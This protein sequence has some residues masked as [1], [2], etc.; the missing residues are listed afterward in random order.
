MTARD[1]DRRFWGVGEVLRLALPAAAGMINSTIMQFVDGWMVANLIGHHALSAQ[2]VSAILSFVPASLVTG[3]VTVVNTF[4]SQ[5]LGAR[6]LKRCGQYGWHG[7]YLA[8]LFG[9]LILPLAGPAEQLFQALSRLIVWGGG[10]PTAPDELARQA[11]YFRYMIIGIPLM[12]M[13]RALGQ[14]FFGIHRPWI[15]F[16]VTTLSVGVN[17]AANYV[18]ITGWWVFPAWGLKGAAVGT[19]IGFGFAF[20]LMFARFLWPDIGRR[21]HTRRAWRLRPRLCRDILRVGWPAGVHFCLDI[22][23]WS[24]LNSVLVAY[25]GQVHKAACAA[26]TRYLHISFMPAIGVGIAA[27]AL[28]GRYI[29]AARPEIARRR[30]HAAVLLA[31]AYMGLCGLAFVLFAR[32]M[33]EQFVTVHG[34]DDLSAAQ[35]AA[36]HAEIVRIGAI[37]L[38]CAAV[39]QAFDAVGIVFF[40]A[41]RGAGDTLWPM[42]VTFVL[43]WTIIVGGGLAFIR[44]A[45]QLG[46]IGPWLAATAYVMVMGPIMAWRFESGAWRKIDLLGRPP[47]HPAAARVA[48]EA[49]GAAPGDQASTD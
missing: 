31:V 46:S 29:G 39:Y 9:A 49:G 8:I 25:F 43:G 28:V 11:V 42:V 34:G 36:L 38:L 40:G 18:L 12:L 26:A 2:F 22:L 45:P 47:A 13:T 3:I 30:A 44:W 32:P 4:V 21:F 23:A 35:R 14:F 24:V 6:R 19:V 7:F 10:Q 41:L 5:N 33:I 15:V 27:T 16:V 37:V 17:V 20:L 1:D 48:S